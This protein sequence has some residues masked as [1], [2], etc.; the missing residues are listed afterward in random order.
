M[1]TGSRIHLFAS[2]LLLFACLVGTAGAVSLGIDW[3]QAPITDSPFAGVTIS[4]DG[5]TVYGGGNQMYLRSWDGITHWGG[6][7]GYV[8]AMSTDGNHVVSALGDKLVLLDRNGVENW[9]RSMGADCTAVAIAPNGSFVVSADNQGNMA[10]WSANGEFQGRA[11]ND[12]A[13]KIVIAPTGNLVVVATDAGLRFYTPALDLIWSNNRSDSTDDNIIISS[14][15]ST[16]ITSGETWLSSY[17]N[18]GE[19]N[20]QVSLTKSAI[21]D[22]AAND[23]CTI[24]VVGSKD[25]TVDAVD[26]YGNVHWTYKTGQWANAVGVSRDGSVIAV[27]AND[28]TLFVLDHGGK[29]LT[30]RKSDTAIQKRSLAVSRDGLRIAAADQQNLY[31]FDLIGLSAGD[32]GSD[33]I[34]VEAPLNPIATAS[35]TSPA[36]AVTTPYSVTMPVEARPTTAPEPVATQKSPAALWVIVPA[37]ATALCLTRRQ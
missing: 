8:A 24:I 21:T 2:A 11:K 33:T 32:S 7:S 23:E 12:T 20:W 17:T 4:T 19:L 26:R 9:T 6:R 10:S 35:A 30:Q 16:V 27:G 15:G 29:L 18:T 31:G 14:D 25:S 5:N 36:A 37:A 28:G 22:I 1:H 3:K 34:Y 13:K